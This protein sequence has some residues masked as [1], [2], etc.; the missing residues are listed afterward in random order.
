MLFN[1]SYKQSNQNHTIVLSGENLDSVVTYCNT[2]NIVPDVINKMTT[3]LIVNLENSSESYLL[4]LKNINDSEI[5]NYL[6]YDTI[7]NVLN[8]VLSQTD[9]TLINLNTSNRQLIVV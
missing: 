4:S 5:T 6:I 2:N 8:W 7:A 9:K 1:V 3:N